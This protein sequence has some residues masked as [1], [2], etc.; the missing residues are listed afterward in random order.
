VDSGL[1]D[2]GSNRRVTSTEQERRTVIVPSSA[3][4]PAI[5]LSTLTGAASTRREPGVSRVLPKPIKTP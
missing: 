4:N 5:E 1:F 3:N 2:D